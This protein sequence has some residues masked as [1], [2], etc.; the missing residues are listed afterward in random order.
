MFAHG[1]SRP[2]RKRRTPRRCVAPGCDAS[3]EPGCGGGTNRSWRE[4][5]NT[6][7]R[8]TP[9][10]PAQCAGAVCVGS[11]CAP[12]HCERSQERCDGAPQKPWVRF[13]RCHVSSDC[14]CDV[15]QDE[16]AHMCRRPLR[17]FP[18]TV[19][20]GAPEALGSNPT[21][22]HTAFKSAAL[23]TRPDVNVKICLASC[24][25]IGTRLRRLARA[26]DGA[27]S[28]GGGGADELWMPKGM[29]MV[30][31]APAPTPRSRIGPLPLRASRL[32]RMFSSA[33]RPTLRRGAHQPVL[34]SCVPSLP[35]PSPTAP[36]R[37]FPRG[38]RR[39]ARRHA[40]VQVFG[41]RASLLS[42]RASNPLPRSI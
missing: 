11:C 4:F 40:A 5:N 25:L 19:R 21:A 14:V 9:C 16:G 20:R 23:T 37:Q 22:R 10:A 34:R 12:P 38:S 42:I 35:A 8:R 33:S 36:A 27:H 18:G 39:V 28:P 24:S 3:S 1:Q 31:I 6:A 41:A 7:T 30:P 2:R 26:G 17:T 29:R 13:P 15:S 32:T